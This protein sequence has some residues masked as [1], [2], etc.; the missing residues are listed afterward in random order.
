LPQMTSNRRRL[1]LKNEGIF[2]EL[3]HCSIRVFTFPSVCGC[4]RIG[5][6]GH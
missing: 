2:T 1:P 5:F 6:V 4:W 3:S